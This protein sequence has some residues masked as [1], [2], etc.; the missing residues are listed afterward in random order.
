MIKA[1]DEKLRESIGKKGREP[2]ERY[3]SERLMVE[4]YLDHAFSIEK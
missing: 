3:F 1:G 2:Y 4:K